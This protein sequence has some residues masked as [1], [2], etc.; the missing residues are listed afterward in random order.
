MFLEVKNQRSLFVSY[1]IYSD[2]Y[3]NLDCRKASY[4]VFLVDVNGDK[5]ANCL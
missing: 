3:I 2:E 4:R 1:I 5:F